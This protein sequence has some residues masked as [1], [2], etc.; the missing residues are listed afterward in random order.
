MCGL[1]ALV[2]TDIEQSHVLGFQKLA[3]LSA[4]RGQDSVGF[5]DFHLTPTRNEKECRYYKELGSAGLYFGE[6]GR[7]DNSFYWNRYFNKKGNFN[8]PVVMVAHAR[9]ATKGAV[10]KKNAHPFLQ[11]SILGVHNGT[12]HTP[13]EGREKFDTDSEALFAYMNEHGEE[14]GLNMVNQLWSAAYA[15]MWV[16]LKDRTFNIARNQERSLYFTKHKWKDVCFLSSDRLFLQAVVQYISQDFAEPA[17]VPKEE[18]VVFELN[19]RNLLGTQETVQIKKREP[20]VPPNNNTT[21]TQGQSG[22]P[23][24]RGPHSAVT[25]SKNEGNAGSTQNSG[26]SNT[27]IWDATDVL[28]DE[29]TEEDVPYRVRIHDGYNNGANGYEIRPGSFKSFQDYSKILAAGCECCGYKP[30]SYEET[31]IFKDEVTLLCKSCGNNIDAVRIVAEDVKT[32]L[33]AVA[34][35]VENKSDNPVTCH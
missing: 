1:T 11:G 18:W 30:F 28:A 32:K 22:I 24:P 6:G 2:G 3:Q 16:N 4:L 15:L 19:K 34:I 27:P 25:T 33:D 9:A 10:E 29:L 20:V 7:W 35:H 17:M 26:T 23:F 21:T 13:F 14:K 12:I 5:F 8:A 31:Y